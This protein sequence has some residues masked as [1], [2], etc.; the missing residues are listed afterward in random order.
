ML[1]VMRLYLIKYKKFPLLITGIFTIMLLWAMVIKILVE[2]G[3]PINAQMDLHLTNIALFVFVILALIKRESMNKGGF[4]VRLPVSDRE[5]V[6]ANILSIAIISVITIAL[7]LLT[8]SVILGFF[9]AAGYRVIISYERFQPE[10]LWS[11]V[12]M[13]MYFGVIFSTYTFILQFKGRS[14]AKWIMIGVPVIL[15]FLIPTVL[16]FVTHSTQIVITKEI[17]KNIMAN[18]FLNGLGKIFSYAWKIR[19]VLGFILIFV[20]YRIRYLKEI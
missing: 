1:A 4:L 3:S 12:Y 9:K 6:L 7:T 15:L 16:A 2:P 19:L 18:P 5:I 8:L 10:Q 11:F 13:I 20:L 17:I 14:Q